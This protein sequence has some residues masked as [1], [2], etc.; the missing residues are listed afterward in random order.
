MS[1]C[2]PEPFG[3]S[4]EGPKGSIGMTGVGLGNS[5]RSLSAH[6]FHNFLI[7]QSANLLEVMPPKTF[8][9]IAAGSRQIAGVDQFLATCSINSNSLATI[10]EQ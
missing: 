3:P 7:G 4:A 1:K 6:Q 5:R 9:L 10:S 2:H 8:Q